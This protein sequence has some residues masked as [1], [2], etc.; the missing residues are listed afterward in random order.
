MID[1]FYFYTQIIGTYYIFKVSVIYTAVMIV[2]MGFFWRKCGLRIEPLMHSALFSMKSF[3]RKISWKWFHEKFREIDF[4][5]FLFLGFLLLW[6]YIRRAAISK[7]QPKKYFV[8]NFYR[9]VC[10]THY[11]VPF[12]WLEKK[13]NECVP[14]SFRLF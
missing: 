10:N 6:R 4:D 13:K 7:N 2:F 9:T 11:A 8:S 5:F 12:L 14:L 3:S 1:W